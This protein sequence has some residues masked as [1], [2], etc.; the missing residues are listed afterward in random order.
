[1]DTRLFE[2]QLCTPCDY[3]PYLWLNY[4]LVMRGMINDLMQMQ[5]ELNIEKKWD[6]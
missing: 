6:P 5:H 4:N 3:F 2:D 1:M